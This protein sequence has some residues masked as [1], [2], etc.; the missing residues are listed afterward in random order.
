VRLQKH[1]GVFDKEF[2]LFLANESGT[3]IQIAS[4]TTS[5]QFQSKHRTSIGGSYNEPGKCV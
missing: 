1:A 5:R 2:G 4:N 3:F